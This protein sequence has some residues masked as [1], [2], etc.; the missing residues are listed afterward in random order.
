MRTGLLRNLT[1]Q[2]E[3]SNQSCSPTSWTRQLTVP[4]SKHDQTL[5]IYRQYRG[6]LSD[7]STTLRKEFEDLLKESVLISQIKS[8]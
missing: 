5:D 4:A 1:L 2:Q 7:E 3:S 8:G 6:L